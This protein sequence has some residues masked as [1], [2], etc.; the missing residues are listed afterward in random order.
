M[1]IAV[2]GATGTIGSAVA[3]ALAEAGHDV[4]RASRS[5][6]Q[7][8]DIEDRASVEA[9]YAA[10]GA[11]DGVVCC[12]GSGAFAPLGE[13]TDA[14]IRASLDSKLLGQVNLVRLGVDRIADGGVFVLTSGIF[15]R[16]P[17]PGVPALAMVNAG[18][19]G[20]ARGAALDL[21]RGIRIGVLSPP[22]ITETAL[23][24]E[25]P[26]EGTLP[27]EENAR[28]YLAFVEGDATGVVIFNGDERAG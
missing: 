1:R 21:P 6:G 7:R 16:D 18:V 10:V 22:F 14:Q 23:A 8:V 12:A 4:I 3:A 11:L 20:F 5:T 27:A 25:L 2:I 26:T 28:D 15:S 9:F 19:E 17:I 24:M 13:L